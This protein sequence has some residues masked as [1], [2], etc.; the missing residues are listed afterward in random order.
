MCL[1]TDKQRYSEFVRFLFF[2]AEMLER[3]KWMYFVVLPEL[4]GDFHVKDVSMFTD[5]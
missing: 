2:S 3:K 5:A 1:H 4:S